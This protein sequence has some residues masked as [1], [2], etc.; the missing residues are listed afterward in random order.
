MDEQFAVL[1]C[2]ECKQAQEVGNY[3]RQCGTKLSEVTVSPEMIHER[4]IPDYE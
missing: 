3:C 2:V 1:V 4:T